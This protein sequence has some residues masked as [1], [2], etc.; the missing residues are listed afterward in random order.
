MSTTLNKVLDIQKVES[1][2]SN[3][4]YILS[5]VVLFLLCIYVTDKSYTDNYFKAIND[6]FSRVIPSNLGFPENS[7]EKIRKFFFGDKSIS[8]ESV[9]EYLDVSIK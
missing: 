5:T 8:F 7:T 1:L 4:Q 6:N 3:I 9:N 2:Q